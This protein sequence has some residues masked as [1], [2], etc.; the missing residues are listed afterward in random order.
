M[1]ASSP[2]D[3]GALASALRQAVELRLQP[4]PVLCEHL[5]ESVVQRASRMSPAAS[6]PLDAKGL[7]AHAAEMAGDLDA[8]EDLLEALV[9]AAPP[10]DG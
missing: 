4:L 1:D 2:L 6:P 3:P 5:L 10:W 9:L 7:T 8:L